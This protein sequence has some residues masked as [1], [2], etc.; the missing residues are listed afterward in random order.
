MITIK[1]CIILFRMKNFMCASMHSVT[2]TQSYF[3]MREV[4]KLVM[5]TA[6]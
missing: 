3:T 5:L 2:V 6:R 1:F 4:L